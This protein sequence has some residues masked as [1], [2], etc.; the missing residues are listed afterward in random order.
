MKLLEKLG[1]IHHQLGNQSL[2]VF[3]Q[4]GFSSALDET[5][6]ANGIDVGATGVFIPVVGNQ[7]LIFVSRAGK[8]FDEQTGSLGTAKSITTPDDL[9]TEAIALAFQS[10]FFLGGRLG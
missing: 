3:H 6:I 5:R 10:I 1:V 2:V 8:I 7:E 4:A 9:T